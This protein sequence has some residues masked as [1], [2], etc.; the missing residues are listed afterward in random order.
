MHILELVP[1]PRGLSKAPPSLNQ[2]KALV[3]GERVVVG[4]GLVSILC[5]LLLLEG[6]VPRSLRRVVDKT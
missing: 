6:V 2:G 5:E 1:L 4:R 3:L